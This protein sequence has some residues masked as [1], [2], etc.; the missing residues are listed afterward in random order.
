MLI[1]SSSPLL[2]SGEDTLE[3]HLAGRHDQT[4]HAGLKGIAA[5]LPRV[6]DTPAK[7][8]R[9]DKAVK[10]AIDLH[11]KANKSDV[12]T[13]LDMQKIAGATGGKLEGLEFRIK[14][15]DSLSRKIDQDAAEKHITP[16][17]AA[18]DISDCQR[19]T[20]TYSPEEYTAKVGDA[21]KAA[22]QAGYQ[23]KVK[24][25]WQQGDDYQGINVKL[26]DRRGNLIELQ[27]HTP[28]SF[29]VKEGRLH[30]AYETYR[31]L[32]TGHPDR[33]PLWNEM[34]SLSDSIPL[35][36]NYDQLLNVGQLVKHE[37]VP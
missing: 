26:T 7:P 15:T 25:F 33:Q 35:P 31:E 6:A 13:T 18:K 16:E 36:D 20:M 29:E 4:S 21:I 1:P 14:S 28:K 19:F 2:L 11:A 9:S 23:P 30:K 24:N 22:Q 5:G 10:L 3:K 37:Y 12:R 17:E 32:P 34:V 27:F 8:E